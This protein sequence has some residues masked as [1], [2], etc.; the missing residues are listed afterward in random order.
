VAELTRTFNEM[1]HELSEARIEREKSL[2]RQREFI[3]DASHELRTPLTSVL[4]NLELL[5]HSLGDSP[6]RELERESIDSALRSSQR[7]RRL[8]ADL[9]ILARADSGRVPAHGPCDLA[10]VAA[11]AVEELEP[12]SERHVIE[13]RTEDEVPVTGNADDLHRVVV[14][15]VDNAV[16][17]TPEGTT[18]RV[19]ALPSTTDG[20]ASLVVEDDGPGIPPE[21][22]PRIFDRFVR[23]A[24][25]GD[26]ATSTG[27][28]LGL[29]I[30][31]AIAA[32]HHGRVSVGE[33]RMGGALFRIDIPLAWEDVKDGEGNR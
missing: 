20:L 31:R 33:S 10:G 5:E 4:A 8:V 18:I 19:T 27:T 26:R 13:L 23:S 7:M 6:T 1:L 32:E 2:K 28:G 12:V 25:P 22:R 9:Q 3:A 11:D 30:V 24:G 17:H 21:V 14:N 15:L 29:A 16:R